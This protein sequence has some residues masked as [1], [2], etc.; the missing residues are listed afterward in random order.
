[1][2][3]YRSGALY[4]VEKAHPKAPLQRALK[5]L[6][7]RLF[8]ERQVTFENEWVWCVVVD[9]GGEPITILEWRDDFG[10]PIPELSE[11]IVYRVA[12]MERDAGRLNKRILEK[13]RE[14]ERQRNKKR[15]DEIRD[16]MLDIVP[17]ISEKRSVLLPRGQHLRRSRERT[18]NLGNN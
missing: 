3:T 4:V 18:R 15:D 2:Q 14:L 17:R 7:D 11:G 16:L 1:M 10:K 13:N 5:Q 6:D 9:T 8:L 12:K